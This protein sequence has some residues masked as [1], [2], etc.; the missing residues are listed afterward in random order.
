[1]IAKNLET[2][3]EK[4]E[5]ARARSG[6]SAQDIQL[7]LVTKTIPAEVISEAYKL[8][9]RDFG[10]NR[11]QEWREKSRALP[12]DIRWHLIG[13]LQTNKVKYCV[14]ARHASPVLIHS[15][16][17]LKLANTINK[18]AARKD[19]IV[20]C[21]IQVNTSGEDT[22][23][24]VAPNEAEK[25]AEAVLNLPQ[26]ALKG[27]MTIGPLTDDATKTRASFKMLR[28]LFEKIKKTAKPDFKILSMGMS[29]DFEIAIEEGSNLIRIGTAVFGART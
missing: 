14:G 7:V 15:V 1:M 29:S 12:N 11:V 21:L 8:G 22:K 25:L 10:E 18:E 16:D 3:R 6:R 5:A 9:C 4:I 19:Q 2:L 17:S 13:H 27:L 20:D 23:F 28:E 26:L 24:G